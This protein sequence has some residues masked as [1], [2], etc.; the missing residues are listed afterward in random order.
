MELKKTRMKKI[1]KTGR[2]IVYKVCEPFLLVSHKVE[3]PIKA[4]LFVFKGNGGGKMNNSK[5]MINTALL[6]KESEFRTKSCV[7]EKTIAVSKRW[8]TT[9]RN[10]TRNS[11]IFLKIILRPLEYHQ[12][13]TFYLILWFSQSLKVPQ[14]FP[15]SITISPHFP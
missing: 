12:E 5:L 10:F 9:N 1:R 14:K 2:K 8:R 15:E 6:R 4:A 13:V 11:K 7:V 3:K